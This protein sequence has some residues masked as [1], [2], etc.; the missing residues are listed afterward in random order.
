MHGAPAGHGGAAGSGC[1]A[2]C[3]KSPCVADMLWRVGPTGLQDVQPQA[4]QLLQKHLACTPNRVQL[5]RVFAVTQAADSS[6]MD[7]AAAP[8]SPQ[9]QHTNSSNSR[10]SPGCS[11]ALLPSIQERATAAEAAGA[12]AAGQ[13]KTQCSTSTLGAAGVLWAELGLLGGLPGSQLRAAAKAISSSSSSSGGSTEQPQAAASTAGHTLYSRSSGSEQAQPAPHAWP[14]W[15]LF[16]RR[17]DAALLLLGA[18]LARLAPPEDFEWLGVRP[19]AARACAR[20]YERARSKRL[21]L[22]AQ[23]QPAGAAHALLGR[24]RR[25]WQQWRPT[26]P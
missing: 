8:P 12:G 10:S 16:R 13:S 14:G 22:H 2:I 23:Q 21:G 6:A 25:W 1:V 18:G 3:F 26:T 15:L 17:R 24:I 11:E 7:A 9:D 4:H 19:A 20:A 5:L